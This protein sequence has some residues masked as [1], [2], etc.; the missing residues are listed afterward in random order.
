M[1]S[2]AGRRENIDGAVVAFKGLLLAG[3]EGSGAI[4]AAIYQYTESEMRR[5]G[6]R[7]SR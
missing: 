5:Q 7:G 3:L 4:T 2:R 1:T 6:L